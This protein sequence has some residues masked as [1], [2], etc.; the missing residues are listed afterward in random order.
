MNALELRALQDIQESGFHV[1]YVPEDYNHVDFCYSIGIEQTLGRPEL[2]VTG[3]GKDVADSCI[4]TYYMRAKEGTS[5]L[6]DLAYPGFLDGSEVLFMPVDRINYAEYLGWGLWLYKGDSFRA[7]QLVY[8]SSSG[9]WPWD[10]DLPHGYAWS[11][12]RLYAE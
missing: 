8:P 10:P 3:L 5:F 11:M 9:T 7:L 4:K 12:L 1:V 6:P 2:V